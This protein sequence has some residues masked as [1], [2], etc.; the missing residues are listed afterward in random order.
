MNYRKNPNFALL[1]ELNAIH[2]WQAFGKTQALAAKLLTGPQNVTT[3][4]GTLHYMAGDYLC[5]G[6]SGEIWGQQAATLHSK[7]QLDAGSPPDPDGW[8][9]YLPKPKASKVMAVQVKYCFVVNHPNWGTMQGNPGDYLVKPY[10]QRRRAYPDDIWI[11]AQKIFQATYS[12]E[13]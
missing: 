3:L 11:V 13:N 5:R 4:E 9:R 12:R 10:S 8:Q 2:A 7:Y 6:S 1:R